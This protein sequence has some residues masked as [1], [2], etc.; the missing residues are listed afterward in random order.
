MYSMYLFLCIEPYIGWLK[1]KKTKI[2]DYSKSTCSYNLHCK[3]D[4][5]DMD[6]IF[7]P[8]DKTTS[9][10]GWRNGCFLHEIISDNLISRVGKHSDFLYSSQSPKSMSFSRNYGKNSTFFRWLEWKYYPISFIIEGERNSFAQCYL[11]SRPK[12]LLIEYQAI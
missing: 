1:K 11:A 4:N 8:H 5:L 2:Y 12:L 10:I 3:L 7:F 6:E 9:H